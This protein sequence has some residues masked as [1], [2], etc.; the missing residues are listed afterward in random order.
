M[1]GIKDTLDSQDKLSNNDCKEIKKEANSKEI[2]KIPCKLQLGICPLFEHDV[3]DA[4]KIEENINISHQKIDFIRSAN[5]YEDT[6]IQKKIDEIKKSCAQTFFSRDSEII[7]IPSC[8]LLPD[9]PAILTNDD[10]LSESKRKEYLDK[11]LED[12]LH[13]QILGAVEALEYPALVILGFR[14]DDILG[15][16]IDKAKSQRSK[17][18]QTENNREG[19]QFKIPDL[20]KYELYL[21]DILRK[22]RN[23]DKEVADSV[24][25][26]KQW[27]EGNFIKLKNTNCLLFDE[28]CY[29]KIYNLTLDSSNINS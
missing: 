8:V 19:K 15:F 18:E 2:N 12:I 11:N 3:K 10:H 27:R 21:I 13:Q 28:E 24:K 23:L 14:S 9:S 4:L 22:N 20:N 29:F 7:G 5:A 25:L 26:H 6:T 1:D 17:D 16:T